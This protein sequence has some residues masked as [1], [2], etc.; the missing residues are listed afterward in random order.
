MEYIQWNEITPHIIIDISGFLDI[1]VDAV[2]A[3]SSQFYDPENTT[4]NTPISSS[5][6]LD[7]IRYRAKNLGRLINTDAGE[8]FTSRQPLSIDMFDALLR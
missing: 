5:N 2:M 6:F 3:Y 4:S 7:S 8:G 1:K